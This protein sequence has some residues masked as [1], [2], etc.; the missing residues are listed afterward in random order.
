MITRQSKGTE[1]TYECE[2]YRSYYN[3]RGMSLG[4]KIKGTI[5]F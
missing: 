5:C 2:L 3:R 4:T 1:L